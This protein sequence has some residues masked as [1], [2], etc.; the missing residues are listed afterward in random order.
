M[1]ARPFAEAREQP[2][3][4]LYG[5]AHLF[6][7]GVAAKMGELALK[8]LREHAPDAAS[9]ASAVEMDP[10]LAEKVHPRV[11]AK[12]EREPVEDLRVDFEDGYGWRRDEEEDAHALAAAN[13]MARGHA[14]GT[15]P[16]FVGIRVKPFG[17]DTRT[18]AVRTLRTFV[19]T[20][21]G[22]GHG[23]PPRF[24]I[25]LPKVQGPEEASAL[26][27]E[28]ADLEI[29]LD[30]PPKS[31]CFEIMVETPQAVFDAEGRAAPPAI[32]AASQGRCVAAHF[33][34]YDYTA[35]LGITAAHQAMQ[36]PVA[37][38]AK[39]VM[40][41]SL[42]GTGVWLSDGATNVMP[43]GDTRSVHSAWKLHVRNVRDS[44][45]GGF[46][47]GWD[48]HPAQL[49]A[50]FAATYAFFLEAL[51][52]ATARLKAFVDKAAQASLVGSVFDDAATG[53]GLVNFFLRGIACGAVTESDLATTGLTPAELASRSFQKIV[54]ARRS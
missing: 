43:V 33:G 36:H 51:P 34:T 15:L 4:V 22:A 24:V 53:Q 47:Q 45:A 8:S 1:N 21:V 26:A 38:F 10:G 28:L 31:L 41:V 3:H 30:L 19:R 39:H 50:R 6:K 2:V 18:R 29:Q 49:P 42:A 9:F 20:L 32:V 5:G 14:E 52:L 7:S 23:L 37:T 48:L 11:V 40:Q 35:S 16:P 17:A 54:E 13:E 25:T 12:L 46:Y 27:T 44:L